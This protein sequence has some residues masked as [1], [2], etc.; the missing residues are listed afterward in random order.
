MDA[1]AGGVML[2]LARRHTEVTV[3]WLDCVVTRGHVVL[4]GVVDL[5][6][7]RHVDHAPDLLVAAEV[8]CGVVSGSVCGVVRDSVCDVV[9]DSVCGVTDDMAR[10]V[11]SVMGAMVTSVMTPRSVSCDGGH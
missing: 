11:N 8:H 2:G 9:R 3:D 7:G 4:H 5:G 10:A 1:V 6:H